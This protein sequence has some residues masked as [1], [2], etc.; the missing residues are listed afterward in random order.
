VTTSNLIK[1]VRELLIADAALNNYIRNRCFVRAPMVDSKATPS[2]T[3]WVDDGKVISDLPAGEYDFTIDLFNSV[4]NPSCMETIV[5][6]KDRVKA[7]L[8]KNPS[9]INN[10]GYN[11][12]VRIFD[13]SSAVLNDDLLGVQKLW[14]LPCVFN[15][16][17]GD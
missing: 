3:L 1:A 2:I 7:V 12:K 13:L 17:I 15:C 9:V 16:I 6:M 10:K 4:E 8:N 11:T 14:H 5:T